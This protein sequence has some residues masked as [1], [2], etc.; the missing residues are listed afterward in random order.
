MDGYGDS[1]WWIV[2]KNEWLIIS[3]DTIINH[4]WPLL[5]IINHYWPLLTI[6]DH[7]WP[8]LLIINHY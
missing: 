8:L 6:I 4:Y 7:Y 1:W 5:T 3:I 2:A